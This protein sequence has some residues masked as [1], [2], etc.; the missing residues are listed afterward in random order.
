M[1]IETRIKTKFGQIQ[2]SS[3]FFFLIAFEQSLVSVMCCN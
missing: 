2:L 1:G 3:T